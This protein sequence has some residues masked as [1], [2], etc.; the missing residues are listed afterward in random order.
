MLFHSCLTK[1]WEKWNYQYAIANVESIP[2]N[3]CFCLQICSL[4][5]L[6]WYFRLLLLHLLL[7]C[8]VRHVRLHAN[9]LL[10]RLHDLC[11]L[12]FL[13]YA[14]NCWF[15][16]IAAICATHLPFHQVRVTQTAVVTSDMVITRESS[17]EANRG[18]LLNF[19][20]K[21][22]ACPEHEPPLSLYYL[23]V[24]LRNDDIVCSRTDTRAGTIM[25][26]L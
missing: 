22:V 12:W 13:P 26:C 1:V 14:G 5:R 3:S 25:I 23:A 16:C 9:I 21:Q 18:L 15:P 10:L 7:P 24:Q 6:H 8:P 11:L 4:W 20:S 17:R 2:R 19:V